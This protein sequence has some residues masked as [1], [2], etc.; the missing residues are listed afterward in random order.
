MTPF[1][2]GLA[3]G[4]IAAVV[5]TFAYHRLR[6]TAAL[7]TLVATIFASL[8][9][10]VYFSLG[11]FRGTAADFDYTGAWMLVVSVGFL[12]GYSYCARFFEKGF[13]KNSK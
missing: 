6:G 4:L 8:L 10:R 3:A 11:A 1:V 5:L 13:K 7:F 12:I 2:I 9:P